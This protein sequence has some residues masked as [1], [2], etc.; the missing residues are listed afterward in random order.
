MSLTLLA[1]LSAIGAAASAT[2]AT[3][4][5]TTTAV[6]TTVGGAVAAA[7]GT[8]GTAG[9]MAALSAVVGV[10]GMAIAAAAFDNATSVSGKI[11]KHSAKQA[12]TR[13]INEYL[14]NRDYNEVD[15]GLT[16][17]VIKI[18]H[19][20]EKTYVIFNVGTEEK[21]YQLGLYST[22]GTTLKERDVLKL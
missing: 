21:K 20:E 5:T 10:G 13:R 4:V 16:A 15:L 14:A 8:L 6:A 9:G 18:D 17:D 22:S 19:R 11:T 7:A 12:L 2:T 3:V 1:I